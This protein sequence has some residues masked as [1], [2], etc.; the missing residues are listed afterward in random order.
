MM[1]RSRKEARAS[2]AQLYFTGV[3]CPSGHIEMRRTD[4]GACL[5]CHR[6]ASH[7]QW[8]KLKEGPPE[9]LKW[10]YERQRAYAKGKAP[11]LR[12]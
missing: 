6:A 4:N 10:H 2:G 1:A 11:S 7:R 3:P 9:V 8:L 12:P 5:K